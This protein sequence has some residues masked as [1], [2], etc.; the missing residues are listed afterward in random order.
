MRIKVKVIP[1][2]KKEKIEKTDDVFKIYI[3]EPALENRVNKR[4]I[5]MIAGYF[6]TKKYNVN[7][8][9]GQSSREKVI[10]IVTPS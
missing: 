3:A 6:N 7:I 1:R 5:E 9:K 10:E 2:A 4:L 8:I